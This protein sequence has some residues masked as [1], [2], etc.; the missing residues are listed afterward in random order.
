VFFFETPYILESNLNRFYSFDFGI[1]KK[2]QKNVKKKWFD[3]KL[4][5]QEELLFHDL[6]VSASVIEI[7]LIFLFK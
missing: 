7:Q 5:R 2:E 6:L 4:V 3:Q 1:Q